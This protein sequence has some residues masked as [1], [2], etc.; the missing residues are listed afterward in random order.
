MLHQSKSLQA[1][2]IPFRVRRLA[3]E[4]VNTKKI[5]NPEKPCCNQLLI[6]IFIREMIKC[7]IC[8]QNRQESIYIGYTHTPKIDGRTQSDLGRVGEGGNTVLSHKRGTM[9]EK[10]CS[11]EKGP[12][13]SNC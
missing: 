8:S 9:T 5:T 13:R 1:A 4:N 12:G 2:Y 6:N 3:I 10:T 7:K 11:F